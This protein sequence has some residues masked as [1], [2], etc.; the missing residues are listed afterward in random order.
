LSR[1]ANGRL[2][3]LL[4]ATGFLGP[5][6]GIQAVERLLH[7]TLSSRADALGARHFTCSL[8]DSAKAVE[9]SGFAARMEGAGGSRQRLIRLVLRR[10]WELRPD[11]VI[12][13]HVNLARMAPLLAVIRLAGRRVV[14]A[15]GI[16]VW[17][18]LDLTASL[19][20]RFATEVW[21]ISEYTARQLRIYNR[22][23]RMPIYLLPL[24]LEQDVNDEGPPGDV[25]TMLSVCRLESSERYKGIDVALRAHAL[26][27]EEM[28]NLH[29]HVVGDGTDV[30]RLRQIASDLDTTHR[31]AFLGWVTPQ[32][33]AREYARCTVFV[34]PSRKEGFGIVFLESMARSRPVVAF[35][36]GGTPEVVVHGEC[37]I[38][39]EPEDLLGLYESLRSLLLDEGLRTRLGNNG[40]RRVDARFTLKEFMHRVGELLAGRA[41]PISD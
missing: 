23:Q 21:S 36:S 15:Y 10:M 3:T 6:G 33:L 16:E 4:V 34:L 39:V 17:K 18:R 9:G 29:F 11:V 37:G 7:Q 12:L 5:Y 26:L 2:N 40:R 22:V 27:L 31:V 25:R 14:M 19:G 32:E 28:P 41:E 20:L 30:S 35:R 24:A 13:S 8:R 1:D 38:L